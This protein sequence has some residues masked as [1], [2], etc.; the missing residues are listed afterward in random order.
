ML[1]VAFRD[2]SPSDEVVAQLSAAYAALRAQDG[3]RGGLS[4][5]LSYRGESDQAPYEVVVERVDAAGLTVRAEASAFALSFALRSALSVAQTGS[6]AQL[7]SREYERR[8]AQAQ[9]APAEPALV[10]ARVGT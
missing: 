5:T 2:V 4:V 3:A 8:R 7:V 6:S 10:Y 9:L 1:K